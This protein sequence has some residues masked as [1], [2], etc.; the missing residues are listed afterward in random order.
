MARTSFSLLRV[1][2]SDT[3]PD[4]RYYPI[5]YWLQGYYGYKHSFLWWN[6][7][8]LIGLAL[9]FRLASYLA[10]AYINWCVLLCTASV[11]SHLVYS[12]AKALNELDVL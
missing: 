7:A 10:M 5:R 6:F 12:Q 2:I 8:I 11:G 9:T 3:Y 4:T 1:L